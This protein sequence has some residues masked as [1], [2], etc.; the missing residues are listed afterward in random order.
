M[1]ACH[2]AGECWKGRLVG[3]IRPVGFGVDLKFGDSKAAGAVRRVGPD[4]VLRVDRSW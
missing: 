2:A 3:G 1:I 4:G